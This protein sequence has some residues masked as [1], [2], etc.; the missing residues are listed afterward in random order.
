[1][2]LTQWLC[3]LSTHWLQT[4][5]YGLQIAECLQS[6]GESR[7]EVSHVSE[8]RNGAPGDARTLILDP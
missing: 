4:L 2:Q 1:M 8:A 3:L 6:R 5:L 7:I